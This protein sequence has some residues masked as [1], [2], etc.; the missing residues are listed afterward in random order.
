[1]GEEKVDVVGHDDEGVEFVVTLL[2][3]AL[4]GSRNSSA[5]AVV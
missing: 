4:Q 1:L 3:V 2:T 5:V